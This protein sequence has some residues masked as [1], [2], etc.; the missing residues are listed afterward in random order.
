[1]MMRE[2]F[3][4]EENRQRAT[5]MW[6][7]TSFPKVIAQNPDKSRSE[8][9]EILFDTLE[10]IQNA[11]PPQDRPSSSLEGVQAE[12]RSAVAIATAR[13]QSGQFQ[14]SEEYDAYDHHWTDRTYGGRGR[15]YS[16][17]GYGQGRGIYGYRNNRESGPRGGYRGARQGNG[18]PRQKKCFICGKP[19]CWSKYHTGD[20]RK[21]SLENFREQHYFTTGESATTPDFQLFL[22]EFEGSEKKEGHDDDDS[23]EPSQMLA[24]L[25]IEDDNQE[26]FLTEPGG[27]H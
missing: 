10:K 26:R 2:R 11:L 17:G 8:C 13:S 16:R 6:R 20:E 22:G 7:Q 23:H 24:E 4:T 14:A 3:D 1:M 21:R 9:L 19:G 25:T 5:T 27:V 12:L 18:G 15:G